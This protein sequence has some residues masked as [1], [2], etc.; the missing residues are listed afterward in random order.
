MKVILKSRI[1]RDNTTE[2]LIR[3]QAAASRHLASTFLFVINP[4]FI[5][6]HHLTSILYL[7]CINLEIILQYMMLMFCGVQHTTRLYTT[8]EHTLRLYSR[9]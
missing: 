1:M 4:I 8:V 7:E 2:T 6:H 5:S 9:I 3:S